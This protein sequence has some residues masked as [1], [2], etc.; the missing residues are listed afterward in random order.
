MFDNYFDH[1]RPGMPYTHSHPTLAGTFPAGNAVR[2]EEKPTAPEGY[3]T[4]WDAEKK[5]WV[6]LENHIGK[7]GWV[8]GEPVTIKEFG[9]LPD[10]W[11]DTPPEQPF[12]PGPDYEKREEGVR[13]RV[14]YTKKDLRVL[15]KE[16]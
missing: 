1:T 10:G 9:P 7:Q 3:H 11:S 13:V 6:D 5:E 8:D 15:H 4:G 12:H 2:D 14:R 16:C